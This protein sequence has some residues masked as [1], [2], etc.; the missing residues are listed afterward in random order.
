MSILKRIS[1]ENVTD[2]YLELILNWRNQDH[3]RNLMY[4]HEPIRLEDHL[5]WFS[6]IKNDK[7]KRVK[8]F[9]ID[10]IPYGV[11]NLTNINQDNQTCEWGFYIGPG[12]VPKGSG[13]LLGY[14]A[15]RYIFDEKQMRKL[16]AEVLGFNRKSLHFH[17]KL[18]FSEEGIL[19]EHIIRENQLIDI[20][21]YAFFKETWEKQKG[22]L[23]KTIKDWFDE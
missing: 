18:G 12:Y 17:K 16:T 21:L 23:E 22:I 2:E 13:T 14:T 11:V 5:K 1:L 3:I 4:H 9:C 19:R 10:Q 20:H 15:L 7:K 8:L 6:N